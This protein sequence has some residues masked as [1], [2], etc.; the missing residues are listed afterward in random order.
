MKKIIKELKE[1]VVR[2]T[3]P[4]MGDE[5]YV[6]F[7]DINDYDNDIYLLQLDGELNFDSAEDFKKFSEIIVK[8]LEDFIDETK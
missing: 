7:N 6:K 2:F 3:N 8:H 4:D 1:T 5:M